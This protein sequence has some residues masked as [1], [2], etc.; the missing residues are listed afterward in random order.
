MYTKTKYKFQYCTTSASRMLIACSSRIPLRITQADSVVYFI[1]TE[2]VFKTFRINNII[3]SIMKIFSYFICKMVHCCS[4]MTRSCSNILAEAIKWCNRL[5]L[6]AGVDFLERYYNGCHFYNI[7]SN[8]ISK[9]SLEKQNVQ[10]SSISV[11]TAKKYLFSTQRC[12]GNHI[13]Y[14][15]CYDNAVERTFSLP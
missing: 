15:R 11:A 2:H 12:L 3:R 14:F 8:L 13:V 7:W 9:G 5:L 1:G 6:V 10:L 4:V